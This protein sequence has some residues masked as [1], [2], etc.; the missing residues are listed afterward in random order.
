MAN[1]DLAQASS[2]SSTCQ[3]PEA[4]SNNVKNL[5]PPNVSKMSSIRGK[6]HISFL[7]MELRTP[8]VNTKLQ[9]SVLFRH[10]DHRA[11]PE[12]GRRLD[13]ASPLH[14]V[15]QLLYLV[16]IHHW[17]TIRRLLHRRVVAGINHTAHQVSA[18][19]FRIIQGE[20]IC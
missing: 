12:A 6:G 16:T 17:G 3:Y 19:Q 18:S 20:H 5:A 4:R 13:Y 10:K 2:L 9:T 1:A 11:C 8:V 7:V 15:Y 14:L